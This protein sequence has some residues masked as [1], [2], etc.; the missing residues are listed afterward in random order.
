MDWL[1][2]RHGRCRRHSFAG[3][4]WV[5]STIEDT[6]ERDAKSGRRTY[7]IVSTNAPNK[8]PDPTTEAGRAQ[9]QAVVDALEEAFLEKVARNR[10]VAVGYVKS[11]FGKGGVLVGKDAVNAGM[12]DRLGSL[13][14]VIS[15]LAAKA[16][17]KQRGLIQ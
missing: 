7:Q 2:R 10:G 1:S 11:N 15:Q 6:S 5:V 9:F 16:K 8:R 3:I 4:D 17:L 14:S 13:E 12:A